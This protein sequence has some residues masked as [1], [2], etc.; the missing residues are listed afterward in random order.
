M[1]E[2][3]AAGHVRVVRELTPPGYAP[4]PYAP[5]QTPVSPDGWRLASLDERDERAT[6]VTVTDLR[7]AAT[8]SRVVPTTAT[9]GLVWSPGGARIAAHSMFGFSVLDSRSLRPG[10][11][12]E[13]DESLLEDVSLG[14]NETL[15]AST[16]RNGV[17]SLW[18]LSAKARV[19]EL[20]GEE[21]RAYGPVFS[22]DGRLLTVRYANGRGD[23]WNLENR[24]RMA[25]FDGT[26]GEVWST[27]ISPDGTVL[28]VHYS[29]K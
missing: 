7:T 25:V 20:S 21:T 26:W 10:F 18:D 14:P 29:P 8:A 17:T 16:D 22:P 4:N 11:T 12:R 9:S 13:R 1:I 28:I 3:D 24:R 19:A 27:G 5:E 6:R 23:L 2:L 15:L